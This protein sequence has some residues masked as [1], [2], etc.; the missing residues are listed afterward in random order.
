MKLKNYFTESFKLDTSENNLRIRDTFYFVFSYVIGNILAV[1]LGTLL[2]TNETSIES[3]LKNTIAYTLIGQV[4]SL[5]L[6]LP[7][8]K[9][10]KIHIFK[11]KK[12]YVPKNK[13]LLII[14]TL[15][16]MILPSIILQLFN[17]GNPEV[18]TKNQELISKYF[19]ETNILVIF[20]TIVVFAP[21]LEEIIFRAIPIFL[22]NKNEKLNTK[23]A[24]ILKLVIS[25][26]IF[27]SLHQP[28]NIVEW[29][30][31]SSSGF[32]LGLINITTNKIEYSIGVH[33]INNF[34]GFLYLIG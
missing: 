14:L 10:K 8:I 19:P 4:L 6:I 12:E 2:F 1:L 22:K 5:T 21:I 34:I 18:T 27:G 25:S 3:I 9:F 20:L 31:Y 24:I 29:I 11:R 32:C 33:M 26:L 23:S 13:W 30:A 17:L 28:R 16:T 15:G 7:Y